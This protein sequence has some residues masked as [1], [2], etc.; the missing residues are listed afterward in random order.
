MEVKHAQLAYT[1]LEH[2]PS[3][4][5][6]WGVRIGHTLNDCH[7]PKPSGMVGSVKQDYLSRYQL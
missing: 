6:T 5:V 2:T 1:S 4:S 3:V 7:L